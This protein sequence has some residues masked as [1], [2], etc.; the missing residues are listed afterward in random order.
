[1]IER[2]VE[3]WLANVNELGYEE[4][5]IHALIADGHIIVHKQKHGGLELGKDLITQDSDGQYHCFQLKGG[6]IDQSK[7]AEIEN[8]ITLTVTSPILHPNVRPATQ[9]TPYLVTNGVI[10]DQVRADIANRNVVWDQQHHRR[11]QLWVYGHLLEKFLS[12]QSSFLPTKPRDFQLFLTLYLADKREPL[13][14]VQFSELLLAMLPA[15]GTTRA[16]LRR[17]FAAVII[18]ADYVISGYEGSSNYYA[19]AQGWSLLTF[20][21]MR[22]CEAHKNVSD[23]QNSMNLLIESIDRCASALVQEALESANLMEGML[24]VDEK[25]WPY[26][27]TAIMGLLSAYMLSHRL[28]GTR[29][30]NEDA[31]FIKIGS[32]A[33]HMTMWG[34]FAAPSF[35][36]TA[37]CLCLRGAERYGIDVAVSAIKSIIEQNGKD[38]K[39]SLADPYYNDYAMIRHQVLGDPIIEDRVTFGGRSYSIKQFVEF[40]ARRNWPTTLQRLWFHIAPI[41]Y[42]EFVPE[43]PTDSYIWITK[44]GS[45]DGRR[46]NLPQRWR[47]LIH[48]ACTVPSDATLLIESTFL[49]V[50]PYFVLFMPH[51]FTPKR[52]RIIDL[53]MIELQEAGCL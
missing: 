39:G 14:C 7:W 48:E 45:T 37:E 49:H 5:F 8:Q 24:L 17:L 25:V 18:V 32:G 36:L 4:S 29:L 51:R 13:N 3:D 38:K 22:I 40:V 31:I 44:R 1:M 41:W 19:A 52:A 28:R 20:H 33:G 53:R 12:L 10:T 34:E 30:T 50:L 9:F 16:E 43:E 15:A 46:W 2:V 11:L 6:N 35:F 27:L 26:R 21:L 42:V 47:D 23:W